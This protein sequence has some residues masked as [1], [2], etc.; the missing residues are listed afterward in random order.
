MNNDDQMLKTSKQ[1]ETILFKKDARNNDLQHI[2]LANGTGT[3]SYLVTN[4]SGNNENGSNC[5]V[6]ISHKTLY[7]VYDIDND[8]WIVRFNKTI[9]TGQG[10][11]TLFLSKIS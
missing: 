1:N 3:V 4:N 11:R 7:N 6:V 5:I 2:G 10:F 9:I 8:E